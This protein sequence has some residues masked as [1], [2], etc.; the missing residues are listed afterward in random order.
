MFED[1]LWTHKTRGVFRC[2]INNVRFSGCETRRF[3][4]IEGRVPCLA[5]PGGGPQIG[6]GGERISGVIVEDCKFVG[7]G[8]DQIGL[9]NIDQGIIRNNYL[10]DSFARN[11]F[12]HESPEVQ[13]C[14]N[15]VIRGPIQGDYSDCE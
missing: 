10:Q 14:N 12:L 3:P 11:I 9:F 15:T 1:C 8:D 13:L 7:C 6:P 4:A 2:G 5:S